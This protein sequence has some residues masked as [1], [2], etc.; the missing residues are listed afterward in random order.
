MNTETTPHNDH[1]G[2]T[3]E[4][5]RVDGR[6]WTLALPAPRRSTSEVPGDCYLLGGRLA[7]NLDNLTPS[8]SRLLPNGYL[9]ASLA[10]WRPFLRKVNMDQ[11]VAAA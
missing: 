9:H 3:M 11:L 6:T 1:A 10:Q 5:G 8:Y 4:L 7:V 2:A